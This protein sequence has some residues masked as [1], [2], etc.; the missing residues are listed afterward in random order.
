MSD[1]RQQAKKAHRERGEEGPFKRGPVHSASREVDCQAMAWIE[2]GEDGAEA[3][4]AAPE[5]ATV[6]CP[7]G[8]LHP[9]PAWG[10]WFARELRSKAPRL[11]AGRSARE[12]RPT[13]GRPTPKVPAPRPGTGSPQA[14]CGSR[15]EQQGRCQA[16]KMRSGRRFQRRA[17]ADEGQAGK[18]MTEA[19]PDPSRHR[20]RARSTC[21]L[22]RPRAQAASPDEPTRKATAPSGVFDRRAEP[23]REERTPPIAS[24][25]RRRSPSELRAAVRGSA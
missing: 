17:A 8:A 13:R 6:H 12:P 11:W 7:R 25:A 19:T 4:S 24:R 21:C 16:P 14:G 15:A 20:P 3:G 10:A 2:W 5:G 22:R 1:G 9:P 23:H 18:T